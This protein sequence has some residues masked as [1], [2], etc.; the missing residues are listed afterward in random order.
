MKQMMTVNELQIRLERQEERLHQ[1][2]RIVAATNKRM[3]ELTLSLEELQ[4]ER[5]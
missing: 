3:T 2:V 4:Q 1:L 5:N